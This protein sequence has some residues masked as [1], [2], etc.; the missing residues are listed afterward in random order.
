[1]GVFGAL[2]VPL[3]SILKLSEA[4]LGGLGP[5]KPKKTDGFPRFVRMQVLGFFKFLIG[6]LGPSRLLWG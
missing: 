5:P 4:V 3:G 2:Q 1:M 6:L